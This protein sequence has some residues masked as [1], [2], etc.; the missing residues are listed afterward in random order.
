MRVFSAKAASS[1]SIILAKTT[2]EHTLTTSCFGM[3]AHPFPDGAGGGIREGGAGFLCCYGTLDGLE[4]LLEGW[5]SD[6]TATKIKT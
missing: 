5:N 2:I 6:T 1:T 3:I 4:L